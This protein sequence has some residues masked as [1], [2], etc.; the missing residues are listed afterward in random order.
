MKPDDDSLHKL[1]RHA[2]RVVYGEREGP[3]PADERHVDPDKLQAFRRIP[4]DPE[5]LEYYGGLAGL[6]GM[7]WPC[8]ASAD[9]LCKYLAGS[10]LR[11]DA[12]HAP[13][14]VEDKNLRDAE[15]EKMKLG[16]DYLVVRFDVTGS[17]KDKDKGPG[18]AYVFLSTS[19]TAGSKVTGF[20]YQTNVAGSANFDMVDWIDDPKS[21]EEFELGAYC[22]GLLSGFKADPVA[23]FDQYYMLKGTA[24]TDKAY[25]AKLRTYPGAFEIRWS[26]VN[27]HAARLALLHFTP[28]T[29]KAPP[30]PAVPQHV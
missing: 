9:Q 2:I 16:S 12:K 13:V 29:R 26:A 17:G 21:E 3:R 23:A 7:I 10:E 30:R 18:H 27:V 5:T 4:V 8:Y 24:T 19:R 6:T 28:P 11:G 15:L 25:V 22:D 1:L 14:P 20:I